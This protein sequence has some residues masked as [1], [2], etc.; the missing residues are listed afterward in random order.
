MFRSPALILVAVF[1]FASLSAYAEDE[2]DKSSGA[3]LAE[4][5]RQPLTISR[6][7]PRGDDVVDLRQIV[8][9][10][11][12]DVVPLGDMQ[13]E[14]EDLPI[15]IQ[16]AL[17]C[18]WRWLNSSALACQLSEQ[19]A[20][21]PATRYQLQ[22][23][24]GIRTL[25]G[26][27]LDSTV[28]HTFVTE[29][30]KLRYASF[31]RWLDLGLPQLEL[32]FN[33]Q[34]TRQMVEKSLFLKWERG[35]RA[36]D[37]AIDAFIDERALAEKYPEAVSVSGDPAEVGERPQTSRRWLIAS[38]EAMPSDMLV[39]LELRSGLQS[40][41]GPEVNRARRSANTFYTHPDFRFLG[42]RCTAEGS[43][44]EVKLSPEQLQVVG[45]SYNAILNPPPRCAPK[46]AI[47]LL[48]SAP[49]SMDTVKEA[50]E[51][52]PALNGGRKDYD[53]WENAYF[54]DGRRQAHA[55][56]REYEVRLP[57]SVNAFDDYDVRFNTGKMTD[58]FSRRLKNPLNFR[59]YTGHREP[60]FK[61]THRVAVLEQGLDSDAFAYV[62]NLDAYSF[63]YGKYQVE[64]QSAKNTAQ[65]EG[66]A[67]KDIAYKAPLKIREL[68]K[69]GS[70]A[71]AGFFRTQPGNAVDEKHPPRLFAQV[72][73]YQVHAKIGHFNSL[74]WVSEFATGKS[75][76]NARVRLM[77]GSYENVSAL[78]PVGLEFKTDA[79]GLAQLPGLES[80]DPQLQT[81]FESCEGRE[82][83]LM[84]EVVKDDAMALLPLSHDFR[85]YAEGSWPYVKRLEG[86]TRSWGT[87]AQ[88]VY[89]LGDTVQFKVFVRDQSNR[90]WL[91]PKPRNY[92]LTVNDPQSKSVYEIKS[93][94]LNRFGAF[95]GEFTVPAQGTTG[96]YNFVLEVITD[97]KEQKVTAMQ[98]MRV[99]V[100]DFTP[101]P[102]KVAIDAAGQQFAP[103]DE[104]ALKAHA[105][106]HSGGAYTGAE[107]RLSADLR[108]S[109]F[110]ADNPKFARF[111]FGAY[112]DTRLDRD[113]SRLI[114]LNDSMDQQGS[115]QHSLTLPELDIYFGNIRI[116]AAVRDERGKYV[117]STA[118]VGYVGRDRFVGTRTTRWLYQQAKAEPV[119]LVVVDALGKVVAGV[120]IDVDIQRREY[121]AARVKGAGNAFLTENILS[122]ESESQCRVRSG[123]EPVRCSFK[124][125]R[126]GLYQLKATVKDTMGREHQTVQSVWVTGSSNVVW[127]QSNDSSLQIVAEKNQYKVGDTARYLVKNPFPGATALVSIE[128]Y[129]VIDHWTQVL[130]GS[131]PVIEF[132]IKPDYLP[133]FYLSVV[134]QS[135]RVAKPLGKGKVDLGKPSY[136][137]GYA[138]AAV[139]DSTK[140]I[141]LAVRTEREQYKP[142]EQVRATVE[143]ARKKG[144]EQDD[145]EVAIVVVDES[146]LA[147]NQRGEQYYDPYAGFNVLENLDLLNFSMLTRLIGRQQFEKKG[148][149]AG[150][151]GSRTELRDNFKFVSY[152]NPAVKPDAKGRVSFDFRAPD[153]LTGW[154]ILAIA[155]SPDE[156][157]GLGQG[158]FKVNRS[159]ELRPVMPNQVIEGDQFDAGFNV[160]NRSD[161]NRS[162][163]L[164]LVVTQAGKEISRQQ[165]TLKLAPWQR[166]T[167]YF[168]IDAAAKGELVFDVRAQDNVDGDALR[169]NLSVLPR[170][171]L[172]SV[173]N[174]GS[175][176]ANAAGV[177]KVESFAVP[178]QIYPDIGSLQSQ[179][180]TT[181]LANLAEPLTYL[182]DYPHRCWEQR[183]SRAVAAL[184]YLDLK[185]ETPASLEWAD[186]ES[187][188]GSVLSNA[189]SFQAENGGMVYWIAHNQYVDPF[190]SAYTALVFHWLRESGHAVPAAV[191][192]GLHDYLQKKLRDQDFPDY[193]SEAMTA[194]VQAL[195]LAALGYA[196]KITDSDIQRVSLQTPQMDLFG[197]AYFIQA[198]LTQNSDGAELGAVLDR[199]LGHADQSSGKFQFMESRDSA[200]ARMLSSPMRSNCALLST[201]VRLSERSEWNPLVAD[202][203]EKL[204]RSIN[205]T[206]DA[207]GYWHNTQEN[208]F[209]V[210]AIRDYARV[211]EAETPALS[212][213]VKERDQL[214]GER[215]FSQKSAER[216]QVER[217]LTAADRGKETQFTID[218]KGSGR[219]YYTTRLNFAPLEA[220][221]RPVNAGMTLRREYSVERNGAFVLLSSPAQIKRGEL[222]RVDLYLS[223]PAAR[224]FVVLDDPVPGGLEPVNTQLGGS[225]V[226][227]AAKATAGPDSFAPDAYYHQL[228]DWQPF[229]RFWSGF[230]HR[231]LRHDAALFYSDYL[232]AGNY[233]LSYTAQ[234]IASGDFASM[235]ASASEM[236]SPEVNGKTEA[237]RLRVEN[238]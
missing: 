128:R 35:P 47:S 29:L 24:P 117:S 28:R 45:Q 222:L 165:N 170:R 224:N 143:V 184:S 176:E 225:S 58:I 34:L 198:A 153:N 211:Y 214:L 142:G 15:S 199:V 158:Q 201:F 23:G 215:S 209:C 147:L 92:R 98:P 73:P 109:P 208:A 150:G 65:M 217:A 42:F 148:A 154:R 86:H 202:I 200:F 126:A 36:G 233:H 32:V 194:S 191:E 186:A 173:A 75:V 138:E 172:E 112:N 62:T 63:I 125:E 78:S 40:T 228:S 3:A 54:P 77:R 94:T 96:W 131:T 207:R 115:Y 16:P 55:R 82:T 8:I 50:I 156:Y 41:E 218:A 163:A 141:E 100:S 195:S 7:T 136:R 110:Q 149:N 226:V 52:S 229:G 189:S 66:A 227:D 236:Y 155:V 9:Q 51:F 206:R 203:P 61:L 46:K 188:I 223:V 140:L 18:E 127:D 232:A 152:W 10:F 146:V 221:S 60:E 231:E 43:G 185:A 2:A 25:S 84:V 145:V 38:R 69:G 159:T 212:V 1:L 68:M 204:L 120:D 230:Y 164:E 64:T 70:G 22:V 80:I 30:P 190:L 90:H 220:V 101:S 197:Q 178:E 76:K 135:P 71:V 181:A 171:V 19:D 123:N 26:D 168:K 114:E 121:K 216:Q 48:F 169:H 39:S 174:Y 108:A 12:Q 49:I 134:V 144:Y 133:G 27:T 151:G 130:D 235:P 237:A 103:G 113:Q 79:D 205:Q 17:R 11:N 91:A 87:T 139:I 6:I 97:D 161:K 180:S 160:N 83:C 177:S 157:M 179:F 89:K 93:L 56:S 122:W 234:A 193:Y 196:G 99:L 5:P 132:P 4:S 37:V 192:E 33:Q 166:G 162:L 85:V 129:G 219:L 13:R 105:T 107:L 74:V 44:K 57:T 106:L 175:M 72:S 67:V 104:L 124:P 14:A 88:G 31:A 118:R 213:R 238:Q 182:R 183:L 210:S 111:Y 187:V 59:F 20:M 167:A 116:E 21:R 95:S 102:F 81:I 119:E 137:M 53:P